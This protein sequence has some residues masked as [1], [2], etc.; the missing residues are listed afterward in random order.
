MPGTVHQRAAPVQFSPPAPVY[1]L[2]LAPGLVY[3]ADQSRE[4]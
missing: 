4:F 1:P 2:S 3:A